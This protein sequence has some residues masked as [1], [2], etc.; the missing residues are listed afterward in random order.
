MHP[1]EILAFFHS[2]SSVPL[3][4]SLGP[5]P[6]CIMRVFTGDSGFVSPCITNPQEMFYC[7]SYVYSQDILALFECVSCMLRKHFTNWVTFPVQLLTVKNKQ[8]NHAEVW[9]ICFFCPIS[10]NVETTRRNQSK[11]DGKWLKSRQE[12]PSLL[13]QVHLRSMGSGHRG[14]WNPIAQSPGKKH[15]LWGWGAPPWI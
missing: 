6:S 1:Q 5:V 15:Q 3:R 9:R 14:K 8:T 4:D 13:P 12:M 7:I 2:L 11:E 10:P